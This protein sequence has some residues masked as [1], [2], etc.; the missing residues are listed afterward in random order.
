M[1]RPDFRL[2]VRLRAT[3]SPSEDPGKVAGALQNVLGGSLEAAGDD[4]GAELT[5]D[6]VGVISH[7]KDQLRDRHVRSAARRQMLINS[8]GR[9]TFV[10]LN[11]QAAAAGIV[12][13]CGS[14]EESPLGPIYL[15]IES[16]DLPA[17]I[18]W[19]TAYGEG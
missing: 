2:K 14:A 5:S 17:A 7:V 11:R 4:W 6:D 13:V 15:S 12:A 1:P 9:T 10:M 18:D 3:V 19:L 16:D 8:K